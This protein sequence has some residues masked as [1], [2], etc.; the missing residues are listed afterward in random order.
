MISFPKSIVILQMGKKRDNRRKLKDMISIIL[1]VS[2]KFK[3][4]PRAVPAIPSTSIQPI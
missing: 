4:D 3:K 2:G 1:I